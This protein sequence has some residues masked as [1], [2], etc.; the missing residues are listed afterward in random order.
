M[1]HPERVV[2]VSDGDQSNDVSTF[3][4]QVVAND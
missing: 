2:C 4:T 3:T 1:Q